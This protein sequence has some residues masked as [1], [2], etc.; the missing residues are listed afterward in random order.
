M[1]DTKEI[2]K[3]EELKN[4]PFETFRDYKEELFKSRIT[5]GVYKGLDFEI[6]KMMFILPI[7]VYVDRGVAFEW[8]RKGIHSPKYLHSYINILLL[9][10]T[11]TI[12][13]F[14][15]YVIVL[16]NWILLFGLPLFL[17]T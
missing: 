16:H 12:I 5:A 2:I 10:L 6:R 3:V 17:L 4:F 15:I 11:M 1:S 7:S 9:L 14:I 13:A 8:A